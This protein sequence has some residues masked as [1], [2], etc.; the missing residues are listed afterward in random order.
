MR[1][2]R[3]S[4]SACSSP[5]PCPRNRGL[6]PLR[7]AVN[8]HLLSVGGVPGNPGRDG[9]RRGVSHKPGDITR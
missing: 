7:N 2:G 4:T 8:S 3:G 1:Y 6:R 5:E 9:G